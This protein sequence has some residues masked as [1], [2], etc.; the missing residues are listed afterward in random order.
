VA[1]SLGAVAGSLGAGSYGARP[2]VVERLREALCDRLPVW[3]RSRCGMEARTVAAVAGVLVLAMA[4]AL[5]HYVAARP[6]AVHVPP[7][8]PTTVRGVTMAP[9]AH[10][11]RP[12][13]AASAAAV[14]VD[15][16][17]KVRTPG[18]ERLPVGSRV[19]DALTAAGGAVPGTDVSALNLARPLTDGEQIVVGGPAS[20]GGGPAAVGGS[21]PEAGGAA[22]AGALGPPGAP[23][24]LNTATP[25]QLDALPGVGPVLARHIIEYRDKHGQFTSVAQLRGVPGVGP[26]RFQDLRA[27]VRP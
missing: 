12:A 4:F 18:L 8:V 24:D 5:H 6:R 9:A 7:A 3:L 10:T 17:G 26:R 11:V 16:T 25:E 23:L 22:A 15:V 27:L 13:P 14:V 1:G 21:V 20:G 2:A 19:A